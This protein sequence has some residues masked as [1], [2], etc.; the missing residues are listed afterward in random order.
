MATRNKKIKLSPT[1]LRKIAVSAIIILALA[2][3]YEKIIYFSHHSDYFT[4]KEIWYE[5]SLRFM[6]TNEIMGIKGKNIFD[7]DLRKIE[8]QLQ[9]RYPQFSQLR[10][11]KRFPN[12][13]LIVARQHLPFAQLQV[14]G[15]NVILD[16]RGVVLSTVDSLDNRLPVI[17]GATSLKRRITTGMLLEN[18]DLQIALKIIRIFKTD[19]ILS[20]HSIS[21]MDISNLS[22]IFFYITDDLKVII[23]QENIPHK[24]RI[25][26]LI[27][28]QTKLTPGGVKYIDLRF[29]EPIL[30]KK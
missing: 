22:Q 24:L 1:A 3:F 29:K 7:V 13:I 23:D 15:Q 25:L 28:A 19:K 30:G 12:Q 6:E 26:S 10:V 11:L 8:R 18:A 2:I 27:L 9:F 4:V 14:E 21:R 5:S 17:V 20:F 16:E